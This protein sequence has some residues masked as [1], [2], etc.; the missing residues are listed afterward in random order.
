MKEAEQFAEQDK[1]RKEAI[2]AK[3]EADSMVFQTE[4]ALQEMGD[5]LD[6]SEKS[7]IE[8]ELSKLKGLLENV[9][10]ETLTESQVEEIKA[11]KESLTQAFYAVSEKMYQQAQ[12][13]GEANQGGAAGN[14]DV[15]DGEYKEV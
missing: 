2:E 4:K 13:S 3:N 10:V 7:K 8:E 14:D 11:A 9:N 6:A 5:K 12:A 15:V 1:K